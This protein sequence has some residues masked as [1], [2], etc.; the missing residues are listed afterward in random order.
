MKCV[1]AGRKTSENSAAGVASGAAT[2]TGVV[3]TLSTLSPACATEQIEQA[4]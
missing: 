4:W 3:A 1:E 2:S